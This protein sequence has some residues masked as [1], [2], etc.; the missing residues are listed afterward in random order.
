MGN[1]KQRPLSPHAT[2]YQR[3]AAMMTSIMHRFRV[4]PSPSPGPIRKLAQ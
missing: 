2:I 3:S 1:E 4:A